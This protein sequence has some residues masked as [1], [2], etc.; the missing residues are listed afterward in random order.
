MSVFTIVHNGNGKYDLELGFVGL[1]SERLRQVH[2]REVVHFD[3]LSFLRYSDD[4]I[5]GV[6]KTI[7]KMCG[8][9]V[10][11]QEWSRIKSYKIHD[12]FQ[13]TPSKTTFTR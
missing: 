3:G 13:I 6:S 11:D 9:R 10:T 1:Y 2:C 8:S 5:V 12:C 7:K 4:K